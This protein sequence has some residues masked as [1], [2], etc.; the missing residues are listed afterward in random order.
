MSDDCL[1]CSMVSG[2][3]TP[4]TV[5][6]S[7]TVLAFRDINPQAPTHV[8]IIP[9]VHQPDLA[10]L[11]AAEPA[12]AAD[13]VAAVGEVAA[14]EGLDDGYR[15]VFNTGAQANQVVFHAHGHILG[16]RRMRWPPG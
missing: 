1:F 3:I 13:L 11:G 2:D 8:L 16:G 12:V 10:A 7:E 5:W 14:Q 9:K 15:V 4:D 6:E